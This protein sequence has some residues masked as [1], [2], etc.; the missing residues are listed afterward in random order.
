MYLKEQYYVCTLAETGNMTTAANKLFITQ[1]A[2]SAYIKAL[3]DKIG[4]ALFTRDE[5]RYIP[6][7]IG[8][9]YIDTAKKMLMLQDLFNLE[10]SLIKS[11]ERGR[12]RLGLQTRRS[13]IIIADIMRF[14]ANGFPHISLII[15]EG[16]YEKLSRLLK[17]NKIDIMVCSIDEREEGI[18][19]RSLGWEKLLLAVPCGS[20]L[21]CAEKQT[22]TL[23]SISIHDLKNETFFLP[24]PEQSLR[25]TCN[26][27]FASQHFSPSKISEIRNI[28]TALR[29]V[30][31]GLG[32][33]FNRD[34]YISSMNIPGI[35][36]LRIREDT[37]PSEIVMAFQPEY[38]RITSFCRMIDGLENTLR[39]SLASAAYNY[40]ISLSKP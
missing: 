3:E 24:H 17:E 4:A 29:L 15:E 31:E 28:E 7:H 12:I 13:P 38:E 9:R 40:K 18:G 25:K 6:T 39:T 35:C 10:L 23:P 5:G 36:Y 1:P 14:F 21:L 20:H 32:I 16:N 33:A 26:A 30:A 22:D 34:G 8:Q 2:L 27:L 11:G 37:I 19:Y